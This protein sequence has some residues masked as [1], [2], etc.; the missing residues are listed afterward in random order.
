MIKPIKLRWW[1][2]FILTFACFLLVIACS[3]QST[4]NSNTSTTSGTAKQM[5]VAV[6][7]SFP[8]FQF[9]KDGQLQG[10]DIDVI[11]G[12]GKASDFQ[13]KFENIRFDGMLIALQAG[14]VDTAIAAM[15]IT[16]ERS[17]AIRFSRPYFRSGLAITVREDNRDIT[18]LD[19][20][21]NKKVAVIIGTTGANEAKKIPGA[22]ISTYDTVDQAFLDLSVNKNVD[23]FINDAPVTLYALKSG[24]FKGVKIASELLTQEYYGIPVAKNSPNLDTINKGLDIIIKDGT[25][26]QI[27]KKWFN[28]EPPQLPQSITF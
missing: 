15:T 27:Y 3:N 24:S 9:I 11:N 28:A 1:N 13:V 10:F 23:A 21:K 2:R 17:K 4:F 14:T 26:A 16:E 5:T 6:Q 18:N 25:Y 7:G 19:S 8:P 12:I 20:L 22:Q